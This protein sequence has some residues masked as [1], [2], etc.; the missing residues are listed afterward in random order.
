MTNQEILK[1][2]VI[3]VDVNGDPFNAG[4]CNGCIA[5]TLSDVNDLSY[6]GYIQPRLLAGDIKVT[7]VNGNVS[8]LSFDLKEISLFRVK[9]VW[10]TGTTA[11]MGIVVLY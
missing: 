10:S 9:K 4:V 3:P 8:V 7:D 5:A 1:A 11:D 6:P 2:R